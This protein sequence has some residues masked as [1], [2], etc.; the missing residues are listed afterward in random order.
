[1][2]QCPGCGVSYCLDCEKSVDPNIY[3][4]DPCLQEHVATDPFALSAREAEQ[5]LAKIEEKAKFVYD[6]LVE[7]QK[8]VHASGDR[9]I[10]DI[11]Y[12]SVIDLRTFVKEHMLDE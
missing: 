11:A 2:A 3:R 8:V 1:M 7:L 12:H 6:R 4:C 5:R 10:R 9:E